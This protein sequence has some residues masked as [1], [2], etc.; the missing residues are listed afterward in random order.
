MR[1][2]AKP[3]D[4]SPD[5]AIPPV[6][7]SLYEGRPFLTCTR[8]GETLADFEE[9]YRISKNFRRGEVVIEYALCLPCLTRMLEESSE[10]SKRNLARFQAE[11]LREVS[12]FDDCAFCERSRAEARNA[13][14]GLAGI[15]CGDRLLEGAMVCIDCI[16]AM[17]EVLSEETTRLWDRFREENFPGVPA[18]FEPFPGESLVKS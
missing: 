6:L 11:R 4:A 7:H 15:C 8:C 2:E 10:E 9:G 1:E 14:F 3:D 12:G 17:H 18:D 16:E 5:G 13:E